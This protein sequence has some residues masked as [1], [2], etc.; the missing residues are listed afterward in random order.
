MNIE[1]I[2]ELVKVAKSLNREERN[3][4]SRARYRN[5][6]PQLRRTNKIK[7][8]RRRRAGGQTLK[9][10]VKIQTRKL[11]HRPVLIRKEPLQK[12]PRDRM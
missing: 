1:K 12:R 11:E 4:A 5:G 3:R 7:Q 8:R 9:T 10:R 6:G 2:A